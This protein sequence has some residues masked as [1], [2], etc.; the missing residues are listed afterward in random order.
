MDP[1]LDQDQLAR[2]SR[3]DMEKNR[4]KM[5]GLFSQIRLIFV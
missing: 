3:K 1:I 4:W 5:L 2:S